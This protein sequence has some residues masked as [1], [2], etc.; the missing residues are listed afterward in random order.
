LILFCCVH[1]NVAEIEATANEILGPIFARED[2]EIQ[3]RLCGTSDNRLFFFFGIDAGDRV[4]TITTMHS[5]TFGYQN[6]SVANALIKV[7][8]RYGEPEWGGVN[9]SL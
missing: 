1:I 7:K 9:G 2:A 4:V 8:D 5:F 6:V 3:E